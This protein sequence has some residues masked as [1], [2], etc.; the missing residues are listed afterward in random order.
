[1]KNT[2]LFLLVVILACA[3]N[4]SH[5][6]HETRGHA[7][8]MRM[9]EALLKKLEHPEEKQEY[10]FDISHTALEKEYKKVLYHSFSQVNK[11]D[12]FTLYVPP[13]N[14]NDTKAIL[15]IE[16][17][18]GNLLFSDTVITKFIIADDAMYVISSD[19]EMYA[20]MMMKL[21]SA[22]DSTS[23]QDPGAPDSTSIFNASTAPEEYDDYD[24]FKEVQQDHRFLFVFALAE[25]NISYYG[26]SKKLG[27]V[28]IVF[29]C[30]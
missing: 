22:L 1:M 4:N 28:K 26:F 15:T 21:E 13:G 8:S 18:A 27:K 23:F 2:F 5:V 6:M 20:H 11:P 14:I 25:E 9:A 3:C 16:D 19:S 12:K 10:V 24:V 7:D 29:S 17:A 30:C